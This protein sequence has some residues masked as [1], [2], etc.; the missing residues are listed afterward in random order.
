MTT[1]QKQILFLMMVLSFAVLL[2]MYL[3]AIG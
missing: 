3:G 1:E 2:D